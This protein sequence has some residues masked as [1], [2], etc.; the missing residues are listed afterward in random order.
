M[1][2]AKPSIGHICPS[3]INAVFW[4]HRDAL[5]RVLDI[6]NTSGEDEAVRRRGMADAA[7]DCLS[8]FDLYYDGCLHYKDGTLKEREVWIEGNAK[9][10]SKEGADLK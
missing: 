6:S 9:E 5:E 2:K 1:T 8:F 7:F 10:E 3:C 4:A